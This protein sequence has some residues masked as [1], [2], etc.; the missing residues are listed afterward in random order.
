MSIKTYSLKKDGSKKLSK[1]FKVAEFWAHDGGRIASDVIKVDTEL[2]K[3]LEKFFNYGITAVEITDG[4]RTKECSVK[5]GG[6]GDDAHTRGLAADIVLY[7]GNK[8][9]SPTIT[10][11]LAQLIGFNGIGIMSGSCHVDVRTAKTYKNGHWWGDERNGNNNI[12]NYFKYTGL[13]K[14]AVFGEID[15]FKESLYIARAKCRTPV[16]YDPQ[17]MRKKK[18]YEKGKK[19]R[20]W[21]VKGRYSK[22]LSGWVRTADLEKV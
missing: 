13:S 14:A 21:A 7:K 18:F 12:A 11:C 5:W 8:M 3:K 17:A 6:G 9:L 1:H 4:Y 20:V 22:V 16:F 2:I 19:A 10:A 15:Y